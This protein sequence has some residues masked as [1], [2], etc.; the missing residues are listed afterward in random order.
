MRG[1]QAILISMAVLGVTAPATASAGGYGACVVRNFTTNL[2]DYFDPDVGLGYAKQNQLAGDYEAV[3]ALCTD[4]IYAS[5][6]ELY[7]AC[8]PDRSPVQWGVAKYNSAGLCAFISNADTCTNGCAAS[9][10][11]P[12]T[13]DGVRQITCPVSAPAPT[14]PAL[15][16]LVGRI[17]V[18]DGLRSSLLAKLKNAASDLS[19]GDKA[20]A[21]DLLTAF[22]NQVS[23][24]SGK[25]IARSDADELIAESG[26][27][28]DELDC[29]T[30]S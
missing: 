20:A 7:C 15:I 22:S 29:F 19:L 26:K 17:S 1:I 5:L 12:K 23:A 16:D 18:A 9:G 27:V 6:M 11:E 13:C 25:K 28:Q 4:D 8:T 21:C 14:V 2:V 3:K 24:Q 30:S 10:C